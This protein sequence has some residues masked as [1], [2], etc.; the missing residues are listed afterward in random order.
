MIAN[1]VHSLEEWFGTARGIHP[2]V[3]DPVAHDVWRGIS[4]TG[5]RRRY[6]GYS[7]TERVMNHENDK[8]RSI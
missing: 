4:E 5:L 1:H 6:P 8:Y 7:G 3:Y 2:G